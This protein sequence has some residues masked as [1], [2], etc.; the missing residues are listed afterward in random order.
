MS[1]LHTLRALLTRAFD[2]GCFRCSI[3][4]TEGRRQHV[5]NRLDDDAATR[6]SLPR[7]QY[8]F[9][10]GSAQGATTP[11]GYSQSEVHREVTVPPKGSEMVDPPVETL[12]KL[13]LKRFK[14]QNPMDFYA[15]VRPN[16]KT[17]NQT[18]R[19]EVASLL[20]AEHPS[21]IRRSTTCRPSISASCWM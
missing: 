2:K 21:S 1:L 14:Q 17:V 10:S 18:L 11:Q 6:R 5:W 12:H 3:Y 16:T 19:Y 9:W 8:S 15:A 20:T 4:L 13:Q 7:M